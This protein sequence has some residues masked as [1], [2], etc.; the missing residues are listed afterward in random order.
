LKTLVTGATGFI[1]KHLVKTL[2][3]QGKTIRCLVRKTSDTR[4]LENLGVEFHYGDLLSKDSLKDIAKGINIVYHL[5][6]EV[7]SNR[8]RNY[9]KINVDGTKNL[10]EQCLSKKVDRFIYLSSIAAVGPKS[11]T[12][13]TEQSPCKPANPYGKSKF[14]TEKLLITYFDRF[15]FPVTILRAPIVYGPF[16]QHSVI[17]KILQMIS[18]GRFFFRGQW[19]KLK[20][21]LL[22]R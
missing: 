4:Y 5:A 1:G 11:G 15:K 16:G 2:A 18:K 14:E 19:K 13:L 8:C 17:T 3:Q 21:P 20:K 22:Y 7:N 10:V 12:L 9:Y 6:G